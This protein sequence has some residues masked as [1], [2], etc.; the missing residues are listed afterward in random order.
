MRIGILSTDTPALPQ[1]FRN[2]PYSGIIALPQDNV[3][4]CYDS[5]YMEGL[6]MVDEPSAKKCGQTSFFVRD[7]NGVLLHITD[8][9]TAN[10]SRSF[11]PLATADE[12]VAA[13]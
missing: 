1:D 6:E 5:L 4:A 9:A 13:E 7:P 10:E 8:N 12:K 11:S 2:Q 3:Q